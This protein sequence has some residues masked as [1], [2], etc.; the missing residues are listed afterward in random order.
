[1]TLCFNVLLRH[2]SNR[3]TKHSRSR[4]QSIAQGHAQLFT[5]FPG[6][7]AQNG[8]DEP[9]LAVDTESLNTAWKFNGRKSVSRLHD[10]PPRFTTQPAAFLL[11]LDPCNS[12]SGSS[13][14]RNFIEMPVILCE[15]IARWLLGFQTCGGSDI[16]Q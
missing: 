11:P 4:W 13:A 14:V 1:M 6:R 3:L 5:R 7:Q 2:S 15:G 10:N 16:A 8:K 9:A 12:G